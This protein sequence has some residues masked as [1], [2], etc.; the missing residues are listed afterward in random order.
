MEAWPYNLPGGGGAH[1]LP[2]GRRH[3]HT[4]YPEEEALPHNLSK[5]IIHD[6][7]F[8]PLGGDMTTQS[9]QGDETWPHILSNGW[10]YDYTI[11]PGGGD[12]TTHSTLGVKT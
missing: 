1:I 9:I 5:R 3:D 6:H 10:K 11:F 8:Y 2:N 4:I 7:T 12:M